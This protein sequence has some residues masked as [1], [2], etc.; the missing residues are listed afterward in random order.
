MAEKLPLC[1]PIQTVITQADSCLSLILRRG[2]KHIFRRKNSIILKSTADKN[3]FECPVRIAGRCN[4]IF[5]CKP[6]PEGIKV[7]DSTNFDT[8]SITRYFK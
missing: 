4:A 1:H 8:E 7:I 6:E 3:T 2:T 5:Q